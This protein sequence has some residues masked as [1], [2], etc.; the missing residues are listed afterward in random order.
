MK[1][2][3]NL[4]TM[5]GFYEFFKTFMTFTVFRLSFWSCSFPAYT[6]SPLVAGTPTR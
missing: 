3:K 2:M 5:K 1:T 4:K 6:A